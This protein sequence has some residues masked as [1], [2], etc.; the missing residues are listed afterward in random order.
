[1]RKRKKE[2]KKI[3]MSMRKRE[4]IYMS[5]CKNKIK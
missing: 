4:K 3:Y 1:M 2:N 5:M